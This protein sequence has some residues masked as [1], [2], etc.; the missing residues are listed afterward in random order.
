MELLAATI[1]NAGGL[2]DVAAISRWSSLED[3][4]SALESRAVAESMVRVLPFLHL[5]PVIKTFEI[6]E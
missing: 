5:E 3:L 1:N 4:N 2:T 6:L